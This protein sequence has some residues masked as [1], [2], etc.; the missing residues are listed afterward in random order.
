MRTTLDNGLT[1]V[2]HEDRASRVAALQLWVKV[3]S[4]D[5]TEEEAGLAHLHE[6]MLFKG[7]AR[8]GPGEVA[9]AVESAGG[10]VNAWTSYDQTVYHV[11]LASE[12]IEEGLDVLADLASSSVFDPTELTRE[13]EVVCEEIRRGE[14]MPSR[15]VSR[16]LFAQAYRV[17]PYKR[18]VIG[19]ERTVRA[20]T[21]EQILA[22]YARH[23]TAGN[24]VFVGVGDFDANDMLRRVEQ[25]FSTLRPG[26]AVKPVT[27]IAEGRQR[28]PRAGVVQAPVREARLSLGWHGPALHS[29]D[30]PA[31]DLLATLL[32]NGD[33]SRLVHELRREKELVN[34]I[35]ASAYTPQDPGLFVV[36]ASLQP[37]KVQAAIGAI[38]AEIER[39][40]AEPFGAEELD[41]AKRILESEAVFQRETV[42]GQA[43]K[44]GYFE[45]VA[46]DVEHEAKYLDAVAACT[47][48]ELRQVARRYLTTKNLT[49]ALAGETAELSTAERLVE[50]VQDVPSFAESPV[51]P[52]PA[53]Y[54]RIAASSAGVRKSGI[55]RQVLSNGV[56]LVVQPD[57]AVP[58]VS[59]RAAW[60]GGTRAETVANNGVNS[61]LSRSLV[62]G[63][64]AR[65]AR[66]MAEEI[67]ALGG[68]VGGSSGRNSYGAMAH[69]LASDFARG[70]ELFT[71]ILVRPTLSET[72][73]AKERAL[74]LEEIRTRDDSPS[75]SVFTLFTQAL[76]D[77]HPYRLETSGT[78][79]SAAGLTG[80]VLA[81]YL[82]RSYRLGDLVV[83]AAGAVDPERLAK[84]LESQLADGPSGRGDLPVITPEAPLTGSRE[85]SKRLD[86]KQ[87]HLVVGFRGADMRHPLRSALT[88]LSSVLSGQGGRLFLELRDKRSLAYTVT[89]NS[90]EGLDPGLFVVYIA[91]SP[92]KVPEARDGIARE[93]KR[94]R[95]ERITAEELLRA[96]RQL[97][98]GHEIGLQRM[99]ARAG[100]M[101]LEE[102]YGLGAEHHLGHADR[103]RAVTIDDVRAAAETFIDFDRRVTAI[104][105]P[106]A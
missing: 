1:V 87:A 23:Y 35:H 88:V 41:R 53:P 18:P 22:F 60:V 11:T 94:I 100:V 9:R 55:V 59:L 15:K 97:V 32:G 82:R 79:T 86:R 65:D 6:H 89:A 40:K 102:A 63:A 71:D 105:S 7:T 95:D 47:P 78:A 29:G 36:G 104:V 66:T 51:A 10:D 39:V 12:F 43:R 80:E 106:N 14:D 37:A 8:R 16:E 101:A 30:T 62:R 3:G 76:F 68:S 96:Q 98:G 56:T 13:I 75:G 44:L 73:V 72:E 2:L 26:V 48:E 28:E 25:A 93:L 19:F 27:R 103:I 4:A 50:L 54:V 67:D 84:V 17:H 38:L 85:V 42:D 69:F 92:E 70:V 52:A 33:S 57:P 90:S 81:E 46:G 64:G 31:L 34:D 61:L 21:R 5:E 77:T 58:I 49:I 91:T 74:V 99:S 83:S 24:M 20:L 45:V